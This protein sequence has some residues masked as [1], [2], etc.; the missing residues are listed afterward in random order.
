MN[1]Q[2]FVDLVIVDM[3]R[4][5]SVPMVS[6]SGANIPKCNVKFPHYVDFDF[7]FVNKFLSQSGAILLFHSND[8]RILKH[9]RE[10]L[11]SYSMSI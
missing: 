7:I 11:D 3:L 2:G 8:L 10:F 6:Q 1:P 5:V 9:I 4:G